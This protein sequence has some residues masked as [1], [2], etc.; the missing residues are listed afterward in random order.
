MP[1]QPHEPIIGEGVFSHESGIHTAAIL[2][3][4]RS[5]SSFAKAEVGGTH[6]FVFG[7]HSGAA[8]VEEALTKHEARLD[9]S[10]PDGRR[11]AGGEPARAVKEL[12]ATNG[13]GRPCRRTIRQ[14]YDNLEHLGISEEGLIELALTMHAAN[15]AGR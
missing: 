10:G 15:R 11:R 12:R 2:S 13:R 3:I 1:I 4:R 5:I 7:K 9:G 14:H 6:R 8:A